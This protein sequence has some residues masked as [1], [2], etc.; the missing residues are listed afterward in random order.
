MGHFLQ[1]LAEAVLI[2][3]A[4]SFLSLGWRAGMVVTLTIP[5]VLAITFVVM[6]YTGITLQRISLGALIIAL[7]LLVD[8]AMIAIE[9]M[10][11]RLEKGESLTASASY[12][13]TSIAFPMLS[14]TLVTV[15]GFIPIGLNNSAA[16]EFTFSLFVVIAVSLLVSWIV[17]VLFAPL[18]GRDAAARQNAASQCRTGPVCAG[19]S[20]GILR[21]AMRFRWITIAATIA[22]FGLSIYGMRFVEQ[23]FFP[24]SD[25]PELLVDM[26][27]PQNASITETQA[28][29]DR[30]EALLQDNEN[31]LVLVILCRPR[32]AAFPAGAG[33]ADA[34]AEHGADRHPDPL[35]RG[36]RRPA[37]PTEQG[38]DRR[39]PRRRCLCETA[40]NR[41][42]GGPPGAIPHLAARISNSCATMPAILPRFWPPISG[43]QAL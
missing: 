20:T 14:G 30:M 23:Q 6:Q 27:L 25:R 28:Q 12:A 10:I 11:S 15:A 37:R 32:C 36:P 29:M 21:A 13:W 26:T 38:R 33:C 42:A 40:G 7:G 18:L 43:W 22:V 34:G 39:F 31:V 3:L 24:N 5:L 35:G 41:P 9:T 17:A 4:V 1:A 8:D 2:V 16:G 19:S